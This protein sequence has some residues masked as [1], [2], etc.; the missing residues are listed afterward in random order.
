M[1]R[2]IPLEVA[3]PGL[4]LTRWHP[5]SPEDYHYNCIAFAIGDTHNW[6]EPSG[7]R[8]HYWPPGIPPEYSL[9]S[10]SRAYEIHGYTRCA[11]GE[12]EADYEK[13]ALFVDEF[14]IPS[15]ASY[16]LESGIWISKLG[17]WEDI[18]HDSL[19]AL[20]GDDNYGT[21]AAYLRRPRVVKKSGCLGGVFK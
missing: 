14:G 11:S 6:W 4:N 1:A 8:I 3:I 18:E 7:M 9:E 13:I 21:V 10:Y 19:Q 2:Q 20:E 16:Q 17:E 15:H 5:A 12:L